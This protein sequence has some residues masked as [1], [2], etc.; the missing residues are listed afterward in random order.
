MNSELCSTGSPLLPEVMSQLGYN[1][2]LV[3][4]WELG[5]PDQVSADSSGVFTADMD[6]CKIIVEMFQFLVTTPPRYWCPK[7]GAW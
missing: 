4:S 7:P 1:T 3:G 2:H 5:C 6:H